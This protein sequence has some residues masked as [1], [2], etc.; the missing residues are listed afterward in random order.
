MSVHGWLEARFSAIRPKALAALTRQFRDVDL[1]EEA[2]AIASIRALKAWPEQGL[3]D[4]PFAWLLKV[5]RNAGLDIIRKNKRTTL[6]DIQ[7]DMRV[8]AGAHDEP[9]AQIGVEKKLIEHLDQAG[10]RDDVLRLLFICCH[11]DLGQQDQLALALK[12][13][14][15]MSVDEIARAFLVKTKT[16]EQRITRAKRTVAT[17][18]IP[19]E[20]PDLGERARRFKAVSLMLYLLFNEGWSASSGDAQIK[21]P[22]C[23]EAIRLAR[24]L[25]DLFP[26]LSELM[27]LLAL[28]LFQHSRHQARLDD[29]GDLVPLEQQDRSR[30]DLEMIN[31]GKA[32]LQ[33]AFRHGNPGPY[34]I[35]A[36][37]AAVHAEADRDQETDWAE[38]ERLYEALYIIQ[39]TPVIRLNQA[40]ALAKVKGPSAALSMIDPLASELQSY[41][42]Y[43]A[44]RAAFLYDLEAYGEARAAY[45]QALLLRP[46]AP[47]K[48]FLLAKIAVCEKNL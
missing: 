26:G 15:G 42:W 17:A 48:R 44:A 36:A 3:P 37:I 43:H 16:M 9:G 12:I 20:T 27:G 40:A 47:E 10:L 45:Q 28:F 6:F 32:L 13:V 11:P 5:G 39:P 41:R 25:L 30:W 14:A 2:F 4:D 31:E 21:K 19:F 22:L 18:D 29:D 38:I 1:A 33:K 34:Q 46:T 35:Q 7:P 8:E 23:S 24:L